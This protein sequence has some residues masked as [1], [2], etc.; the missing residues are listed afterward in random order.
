MNK[1]TLTGVLLAVLLI[2]GLVAG[3]LY[4]FQEGNELLFNRSWVG[5]LLAAF[6]GLLM[7]GFTRRQQPK[8]IGDKVLRHD[9]AA[10][11]EHWTHAVGTLVLIVSGSAIGFLFV[12]NMVSTTVTNAMLNVHYVGA[13]YFLFGTFYYLG[14]SLYA[15]DRVKEH[16]P[17]RNAIKYTIQ[18]YGHLLGLK[19][20]FPTLPSEKK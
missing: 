17:T 5:L 13:L 14:N 3:W 18:H 4:A 15:R 16:L 11:L 8:I 2:I 6:L 20:K 9:N 7:A 19:K 1:K 10:I 12:P